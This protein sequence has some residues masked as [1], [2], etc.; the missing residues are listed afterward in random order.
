MRSKKK[1]K[2]LKES[3]EKIPHISGFPY[4]RK[5]ISANGKQRSIIYT[6]A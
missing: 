2:A 1:A 4:E 5:F 6:Y 3:G